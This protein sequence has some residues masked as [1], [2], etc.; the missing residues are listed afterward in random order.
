MYGGTCECISTSGVVKGKRVGGNG[1]RDT[2]GGASHEAPNASW[3]PYLDCK[4]HAL[5][6][7]LHAA[8]LTVLVVLIRHH[9]N[10]LHCIILVG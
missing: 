5:P 2:G 9:H 4:V 3:S 7:P 1:L 8:L 6:L 10:I